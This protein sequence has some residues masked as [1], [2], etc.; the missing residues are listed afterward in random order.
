MQHVSTVM[1]AAAL[2]T[3]LLFQISA[4]REFDMIRPRQARHTGIGDG[5]DK[6]L[7]R[8]FPVP[9]NFA[10]AVPFALAGLSCR[11]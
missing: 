8:A 1:S 7:T 4:V 11:P 10:E 2:Y 6:D 3:G 5:Q 9:D